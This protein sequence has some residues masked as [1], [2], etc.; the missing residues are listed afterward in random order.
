MEDSLSQLLKHWAIPILVVGSV[1]DIVQFLFLG[2][3]A[4]SKYRQRMEEKIRQDIYREM[5]RQ[6]PVLNKEEG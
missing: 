1:V 3:M 4:W 2:K 6:G 5:G